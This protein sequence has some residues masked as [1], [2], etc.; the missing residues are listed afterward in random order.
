M[1]PVT[2]FLRAIAL[3]I[4]LAAVAC[5]GAPPR[6]PAPR[7]AAA[8]GAVA[9]EPVALDAETVSFYRERDLQPL[10]VEGRALSADAEILIQ[11][12]P[13]NSELAAA[14]GAA[15]TGDPRA[16]ARADLLLT[17]AFVDEV[18]ERR[19]PPERGRMRYIDAGLA[20]RA[21][22]ERDTLYALAAAPS[23]AGHVRSALRRNPAYDGLQRG[24]AAYRA[25]WSRL[26]QVQVIAGRADLLRQRLGVRDVAAGLREFQGVHGLRVTG[27]ADGATL[28]ALNRGAIHYERLILANIER[29]RAIPAAPGER[30]VLVD[31]AS[32]RLFM[33]EDGQIR[34]SMRVIVG[35]SAMPT[36]EM[37]GLIRYAALNPY[38]NLPPDLIRKRARAALRNPGAIAAERLQVLSD[39]SPQA[40][41]LQPRQ[42]NWAAVA[43]GGAFVNLRQ[44]PGP[45]NMMGRVK[46]MLPNDLG[47]YLHD[48]PLR[49]LF[50]GA[51]RRQSSGCIRLEDAQR[52]GRWL[53]Q[54][55]MP[56]A[57]GAAEQQAD[58]PEPVPVYIT[59]LTVLPTADGRVV[60]LADG[61]NRD[62]S[63]ASAPRRAARATRAM[64]AASPAR[65][66]RAAAA[67]PAP[68]P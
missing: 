43:A 50:A 64:P 2:A 15:R 38:W 68:R 62:S 17:R 60:F 41:V 7:A 33:V 51:D 66:G 5:F 9:A 31:T 23:L 16:L 37:A 45:Q 34:D 19:R 65:R 35:K 54:G 8:H 47:V 39:W 67:R 46:Y 6:G 26:P 42:V 20:P 48:T 49:D 61:Y 53:F 13:A 36:P 24:L 28:A 14:V 10:W 4:G 59:Y 32:A 12:L 44:L 56:R 63:P 27:R 3:T 52:L 21:A 40:R 57:T 1:R 29:A 30:Y 25:R 22:S 11:A 58:L 55:E 18:G